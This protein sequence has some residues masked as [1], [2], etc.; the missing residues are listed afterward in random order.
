MLDAVGVQLRIGYLE[1]D[2]RVDLHGDIILG[3][4]GLRGEVCYL[5]LE[6]DG[7]CNSL[8]EG[9][10]EVDAGAPCCLVLADSLNYHD[11]ALLNDTY[12]S[13]NDE[14][15]KDRNYAPNN[16]IHILSSVFKPRGLFLIL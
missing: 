8:K 7:L 3:D 13:H 9:D 15:R 5:L 11:L 2:D 1:I 6:G 4:N 16:K 10:L 12:V 14:K